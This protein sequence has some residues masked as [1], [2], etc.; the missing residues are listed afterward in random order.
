MDASGLESFQ[1]GLILTLSL[2]TTLASYVFLVVFPVPRNVTLSA[3]M[4][5]TIGLLLMFSRN[6]YGF[7]TIAV[8]MGVSNSFFSSVIIIQ[9]DFVR[10]DYSVMMTLTSIF[11]IVGVGSFYL[12]SVV[13]VNKLLALMTSA[14]ILNVVVS[15]RLKYKEPRESMRDLFNSMKTVGKTLFSVS[16]F[17]VLRKVLTGSY[18]PLILLSSFPDYSPQEISLYLALS[19]IP[20]ISFLYFGHR[21]NNKAFL[22]LSVVELLLFLALSSFYKFSLYL[23]LALI[24]LINA[25]GYLRAPVT[26]ETVVKMMNFSTKLSAFFNLIDMMFSSLAS[27]LFAFLIELDLYYVIFLLTGFSSFL[28]SLMIYRIMTRESKS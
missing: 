13:G 2:V 8:L 17:S 26:E 23:F 25:G 28:S 27:T 16:F 7:V 22:V 24:L 4:E 5:V 1:I 20:L 9:K 15:S 12:S 11:S 21:T 10:K 14:L 6:I 18:I 3:L 19:R